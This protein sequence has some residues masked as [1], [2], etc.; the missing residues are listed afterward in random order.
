M[1]VRPYLEKIGYVA[2]GGSSSGDK[3]SAKIVAGLAK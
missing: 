2:F 3:T 1:D